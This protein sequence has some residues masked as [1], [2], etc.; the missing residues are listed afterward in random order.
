[1]FAPAVAVVIVTVLAW[2]MKKV[3]P[4][5]LKLAWPPAAAGKVLP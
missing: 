1:M 4:S 5:G 2:V 3:P